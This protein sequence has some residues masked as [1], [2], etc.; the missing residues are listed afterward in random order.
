MRTGYYGG[1][2]DPIHIGHLVLAQ[3]ARIA[4]NLDQVILIPAWRA[5][6][7]EG[8]P[9]APPQVRL[10]LCQAAV[11]G[12]DGVTVSDFEIR[13]ASTTFS[14]ETV[15]HF[16]NETPEAER[17]WILGADQFEQLHHWQ[18]PSE[19]VRCL[20]FLVAPRNRDRI[21]PPPL[22]NLR[23][24]ILPL[25]RIDVSATEIRQRIQDRKPW[26]ALVPAP[27]ATAIR[28]GSHYGAG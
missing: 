25:R 8:S 11:A 15:A 28:A 20:T 12:I 3:E 13:R 4:A 10:N 9:G 1:S 27:V 5:P 19:L 21:T 26:E 7:R 14:W 2:F 22:P 17:F 18:N 23:Y 24:T 16:A 6:L